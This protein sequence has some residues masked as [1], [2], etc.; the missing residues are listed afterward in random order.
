MIRSADVI[1]IS[2]VVFGA[3]QVDGLLSFCEL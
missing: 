1:K 2:A 3:G